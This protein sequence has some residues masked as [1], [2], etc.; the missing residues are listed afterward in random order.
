MVSKQQV[1]TKQST[2]MPPAETARSV[3]NRHKKSPYAHFFFQ[4]GRETLEIFRMSRFQR[5]DS[6]TVIRQQVSKKKKINIK[7]ERYVPQAESVLSLHR[8]SL[9]QKQKVLVTCVSSW[10]DLNYSSPSLQTL[11]C[12]K[13]EW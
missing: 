3:I 12:I 9:I 5:K 4:L 2:Y 11:S 1:N 13:T 6:K 7:K 10:S 8:S